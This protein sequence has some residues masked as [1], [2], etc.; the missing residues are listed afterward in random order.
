MLYLPK[1]FADDMI[2]H[3]REDYPYE[4]CGMLAGT[5][6]RVARVYRTTNSEKSETRYYM[7]PR[8]QLRFMQDMDDKGLDLLAIYHSHPKTQAYPSVTDVGLAFYPESLYVIL[9]LQDPQAPQIRAFTIID[10]QIEEQE[11]VIED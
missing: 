3:A 8:E 6:D 1:R 7:E 9:T 10:G 4:V 11:I 2:A 5:N